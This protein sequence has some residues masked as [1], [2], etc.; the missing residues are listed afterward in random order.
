MSLSSFIDDTTWVAIFL[1]DLGQINKVKTETKKKCG[2]LN[3]WIKK[4]LQMLM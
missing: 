3:Y 4:Q 2:L 1:R